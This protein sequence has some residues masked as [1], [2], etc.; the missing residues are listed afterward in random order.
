[1]Q[2]QRAIGNTLVDMNTMVLV[3]VM[4]NK[5]QKVVKSTNPYSRKNEGNKGSGNS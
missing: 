3:S 2:R 1:M 5:G 4:D